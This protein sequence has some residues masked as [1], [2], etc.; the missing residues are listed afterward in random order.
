VEWSFRCAPEVHRRTKGDSKPPSHAIAYRSVVT[1]EPESIAW[2]VP[3]DGEGVPFGPCGVCGGLSFWR[4]IASDGGAV[5]S[6]RSGGAIT[7]GWQDGEMVLAGSAASY[8]AF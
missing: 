7:R 8:A 6:V 4:L 2:T 3:V 5:S 1:P